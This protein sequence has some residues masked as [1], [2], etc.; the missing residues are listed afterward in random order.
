[1]VERVQIHKLYKTFQRVCRYAYSLT[2]AHPLENEEAYEK[3]S[4]RM[5]V[6]AIGPNLKTKFEGGALVAK[7]QL[8]TGAPPSNL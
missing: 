8:A 6:R 7:H 3:K 4:I 2:D 5:L 1:M